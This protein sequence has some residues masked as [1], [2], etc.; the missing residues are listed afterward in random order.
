MN[1]VDFDKVKW[2]LIDDSEWMKMMIAYVKV[3]S[4]EKDGSILNETLL[5]GKLVNK[6]VK[7]KSKLVIPFFKLTGDMYVVTD[8]SP[9]MKL[10]YNERSLGIFLKQTRDLVQMGRGDIID[11]HEY[12]FEG[13]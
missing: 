11:I 2:F 9:E 1:S 3:S 8:Y 12:F 13:E 5:E 4:E 6:G 10:L 7:V